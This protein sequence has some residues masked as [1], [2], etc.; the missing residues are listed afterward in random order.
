MRSERKP[1]RST[2]AT[3]TDTTD[4]VIEPAA[5]AVEGPAADAA[6]PNVAV[7]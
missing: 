6:I 2:V 7:G 4:R 3:A 5:F 1:G